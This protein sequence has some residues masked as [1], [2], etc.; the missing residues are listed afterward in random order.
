VPRW[1]ACK[2]P[3]SHVSCTCRELNLRDGKPSVMHDK[4]VTW[5]QKLRAGSWCQLAHR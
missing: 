5:K 4:Q 3:A 2:S 1:H